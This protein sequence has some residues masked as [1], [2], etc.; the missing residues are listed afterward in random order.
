VKLPFDLRALWDRALTWYR[1]HG[2]RDRRIILGV[3][4]AVGLSL[5]YVGVVEPILD[6][7]KD[8]LAQIDS[9]H[10]KLEKSTKLV[11]TKDALRAE[12]DDLKKRLAQAKT[13]LLPGGTVT[14]GA[15][16][17]QER[18]NSLAQ[19]K[20]IAVQSTQVM[21]EAEADPFKKVSVRLTLSGE[22]N[23]L[24]EFVSGVEYAQQLAIPFI[25]I[26]RRGA[27][28]GAKGPRT[29]SVTVEVS[30]FVQGG[31]AGKPEGAEGEGAPAEGTGETPPGA[32]GQAPNGGAGAVEAAAGGPGDGAA[33]PGAPVD[34]AP[35]EGAPAPATAPAPAADAKPAG[36]TPPAAPGATT[37]PGAAAP[38]TVPPP[39]PGITFP[40]MVPGPT[41]PTTV[42]PPTATPTTVAAP[43]TMPPTTAPAAVV[44]PK[45]IGP[46]PD[47]P[48]DED[49]D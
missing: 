27:V 15:A 11:A 22:L 20:G 35:A 25:E 1:S 29:L 14:L 7:R 31:A 37:P 28:A 17:L 46:Q 18:T 24:A 21:K 9:D 33:A 38:A 44:P 32:D 12:R 5:V 23:P 30:G 49:N 8:V 41:T 39:I 19:E 48:D 45:L 16:A 40:P 34:G 43:A 26:S 36:E 10:A 13:R 6:Y 2:E 47:Q 3:L 42:A 4:I